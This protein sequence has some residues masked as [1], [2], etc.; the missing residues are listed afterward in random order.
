MVDYSRLISI[1]EVILCKMIHPN[2]NCIT[3]Y[4]QKIF[5]LDFVGQIPAKSSFWFA[6][7]T[8]SKFC[9]MKVKTSHTYL[10]VYYIYE[11]KYIL[12][13]EKACGI[14]HL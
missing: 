12:P 11:P 13:N 1:L 10:M 8:L 5:F 4:D 3:I 6:S 7:I 14:S 9:P 2:Y